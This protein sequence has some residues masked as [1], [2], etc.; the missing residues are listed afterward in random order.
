MLL[1]SEKMDG[2]FLICDSPMA[3]AG[4]RGVESLRHI[5]FLNFS[6]WACV[7]DSRCESV[8][9]SRGEIPRALSIAKGLYSWIR[10]MGRNRVFF[11]ATESGGVGNRPTMAGCPNPILSLGVLLLV[12]LNRSL[13]TN[14][15]D[16]VRIIGRSSICRRRYSGAQHGFG[17][18]YC[19]YFSTNDRPGFDRSHRSFDPPGSQRPNEFLKPLFAERLVRPIGMSFGMARPVFRAD[20]S[21][22]TCH[23]RRPRLIHVEMGD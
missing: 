19:G 2:S 9:L 20:E 16:R 23:S 13:S 22:A 17:R 4:I 5:D 11:Y 14:R 15:A 8:G 10:E 7:G 21:T 6:R 12:S 18:A 1:V 3:H